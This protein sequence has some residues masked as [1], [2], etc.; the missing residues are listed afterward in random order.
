MAALK[1]TIL[2]AQILIAAASSAAAQQAETLTSPAIDATLYRDGAITRFSGQHDAWRY[3][4]DEVKQLKQRFCSLRTDVR[5]ISGA[6]LAEMTVSTGEDGRPAALLRMASNQL[7]DD[8]VDIVSGPP[9]AMGAPGQQPGQPK[10][11]KK[12]VYRV[13]PA[14]CESGVCQ[15]IWTLQPGQIAALNSGAGLLM[16]YA[17]APSGVA[18]AISAPK[19]PPTIEAN[20]RGAGFVT[21]LADSLKP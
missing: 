17:V 2:W 8:G 5:D 13:Y 20:I 14:A 16:R 19:S 9:P 3:V 10:A 6:L 7:T 12:T 11:A 4:C 1:A 18:P 21:A 15:L